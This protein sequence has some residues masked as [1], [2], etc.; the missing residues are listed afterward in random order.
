MKRV[1]LLMIVALL[2]SFS[3]A[4]PTWAAPRFAAQQAQKQF[5]SE[6]E[7]TAYTAYYEVKIE[8]DPAKKLAMGKEFLKNFPD[9]DFAQSVK[10]VNLRALG[11]IF[12][13]QLDAYYKA[14]DAA[15]LSQLLATG[16]EYLSSQ[17]DQPYFLTHM[18]MA[19]GY[20]VLLGFNKDIDKS[21][22]YAEKAL[23]RLESDTPP[24]GWK[25]EEWNGFRS[26]S[27]FLGSLNQYIAMY[28]L[29][30]A[31]PDPEKVIAHLTKAAEHKDWPAAK[32]PNTYSLRAQ[33]NNIIYAKLGAEY[34]SLSNDD[35]TGEKGKAILEKI[36]PVVDKMIDDYAR[37]VALL[38]APQN[39]ALRDDA[40]E[41]LT[42]LYKYRYT[43]LDGLE[44]LIKYYEKDPTA[45]PMVIK[46]PSDTGASAKDLPSGEAP[47]TEMAKTDG[48][49]GA[50]TDASKTTGKTAASK[51]AASKTTT[52][53][54][55][56]VRKKKESS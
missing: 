23:Q 16:E 12:Q 53:K 51:T 4:L 36:N 42:D 9:S 56:P 32:D 11:M 40:K 46:P 1:S 19:S 38:S 48:A 44:D 3:V 2:A 35:K 21:K 18:A 28:I 26:N 27:A 47:K 31:T 8:A 6:A 29:R 10:D 52:T 54:K 45:P 34:S 43:K 17:S 15:K 49:N 50:K 20:G 14:A 5:K 37:A 41:R 13:A 25:P 39:K 24:Q 7:R 55:P 30:D 22:A 33:A